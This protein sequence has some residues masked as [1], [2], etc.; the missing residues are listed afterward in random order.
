MSLIKNHD[1]DY[2][3]GIDIG[4]RT[5]KIAILDYAGNIIYSD[6]TETVKNAFSTYEKLIS[7]VPLNIKNHIKSTVATG[8]GRNAIESVVNQ[9]LTEI[10]AH[11][12]GVKQFFPET[13]TVIDIGGQDSKVIAVENS[14]I[15]DFSMND[16]CAAGT[17]RFIEVMAERLGFSFDEIKA[18]DVSTVEPVS[19]NAT[20]TVFAESE[21]VSLMATDID[22]KRIIASIAKMAALN[23][24][25]MASKL[26][27]KP[28]FVMTGGVS[29]LQPVLFF[30]EKFFE[31]EIRVHQNSQIMGAIG[32]ALSAK[33][34]NDLIL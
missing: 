16:R 6:I 3:A 1:C 12:L 14:V 26:H 28:P 5:G 33:S 17:G 7:A 4:S 25:S 27:A 29:K 9:T 24:F 8:Y 11:Y 2:F 22:T 19:I 34:H 10:T 31:T 18:L 15:R 21:V 13:R 23:I 30:L 20:C 32:A